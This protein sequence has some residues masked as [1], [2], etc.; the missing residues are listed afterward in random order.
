VAIV[1]GGLAGL[2]A[3]LALADAR[4]R[5]TL[6]EASLAVGGRVHSNAGYWADGQVTEWCGE[7]VNSDHDTVLSLAK[8]FQLE[9]IDLPSE[10]P[11]GGED[12]F[13][14]DGGRYPEADAARD[15]RPVLAALRQDA[16]AAGPRTTY[17]I[18]TPRGVAL[19]NTSVHTWIATRVPGG[20]GSPLG[21]LLDVAYATEFGAPTPEQSALN[22]VYL[23]ADQ[24]QPEELA[25][26]GASDERYRLR[27]GN[28]GLPEAIGRHLPGGT[29]RLGWRLVAV[30]RLADGALELSFDTPDGPATARADH[31]IVT[32]PFAVLGEADLTRV[33]LDDRKR[34]AIGELGRG[35]NYKL[36]LQFT[37]R[38]WAD[39]AA[40]RPRSG[41]AFADTGAGATWDTSRGQPGPSG[42]LVNFGLVPP[43]EEPGPPYGD[44]ATD[45]AV[46]AR[47][48]AHLQAL[49]PVWPGITARW[50]GRATLSRPSLDENAGCSYA[51]YRVGQYHR[52]GGYEGVR[53]GRL[54]FAGEHCSQEYQGYME[55]AAA[56]GLR[57][58]RA[59]LADL[60][61]RP[62]RRR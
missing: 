37:G 62:A 29:V 4:V 23:L 56:E 53:H 20:H 30:S 32:V 48:R 49:E 38:F 15:F 46:A 9:P 59:V 35:R 1:G 39:A 50:N 61:G 26:F 21:R 11:V 41:A 12:T 10:P 24:P 60:R 54:H 14:V 34:L 22:L 19:D 31:A 33:R 27:G 44:A 5:T 51:Y 18:H 8:R 57:A 13:H 25:L 6:Y 42:L 52:F 45:P 7:F 58:A 28:G 16:Q 40:G 43:G 36:H 55:G 47:A 2:T 17:A 3:A